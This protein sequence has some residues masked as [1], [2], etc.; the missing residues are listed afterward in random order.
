MKNYII[1]LLCLMFSGVLVAQEGAS[2]EKFEINVNPP[3]FLVLDN[4]YQFKANNIRSY[5]SNSFKASNV[6]LDMCYGTS[7]I[8]F[9]INEKGEPENFK[10]I[11]S[12]SKEVDD[13]IIRILES[14]EGMWK[15]GMNNGMP[16]SMEQ[17]V[18]M[19]VIVGIYITEENCDFL[20][21]AQKRFMKGSKLLLADGK[22][23]RAL[24]QFSEGIRLMPDDHSLL[25]ARGLCYY[26]LGKY[27]KARTDWERLR[28][29]GGVNMFDGKILSMYAA[30]R[31]FEEMTQILVED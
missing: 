23:R 8:S 29:L 28:D 9:V 18:T 24:N 13:E 11:N 31:G 3:K 26:E 16:V 4:P 27:D 25:M 6:S 19:P 14:T 20:S 17:Q 1:L 5:V 15:P 30:L 12:V 7:I 22:P 10:V 2:L 21:M